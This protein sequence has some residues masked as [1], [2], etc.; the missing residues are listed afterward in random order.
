M[1]RM[2]QHFA[3]ITQ[4]QA[5][6]P[7]P[8]ESCY[9]VAHF[10]PFDFAPNWRPAN[11]EDSL[12]DAD[13]DASFVEFAGRHREFL[14]ALVEAREFNSLMIRGDRA[15]ER[16][17]TVAHIDTGSQSLAE[18]FARVVT[19]LRYL[20]REI[21]APDDWTPKT[22]LDAPCWKW[23][24]EVASRWSDKCKFT[25][26]DK[27]ATRVATLNRKFR[28]CKRDRQKGGVGAHWNV[29]LAMEAEPI[30]SG[31]FLDFSGI[32]GTVA[33]HEYNR[34]HCVDASW[35]LSA[36]VLAIV[37]GGARNDQ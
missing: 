11:V 32:R 24:D 18:M 26:L 22:L 30:T 2:L 6:P 36:A 29:V 14:A 8:G 34:V 17:A 7:L 35:P 4:P 9:R 19:P 1:N 12:R 13:I 23:S 15:P 25:T 33:S 31:V 16:W 37:K 5:Q 28:K 27:A 20:T 21:L 3:A 10:T